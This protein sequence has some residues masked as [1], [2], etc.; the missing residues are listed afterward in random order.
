MTVSAS[1]S[2][3][4]GAAPSPCAGAAAR[5]SADRED[6]MT[7][8]AG[9]R[10]VSKNYGAT[11]RCHPTDLDLHTGVTGLLG[12]NGAGKSTLLRLLA[13]A[14]PPSAGTIAVAG[15]EVTGSLAERTE[16][17]RLVGY[18]PQEL[19]L[20]P[21]SRPSIPRLHRRPQGMDRHQLPAPGGTPGARPGRPRRPRH[22]AHQRP[23]RRATPPPRA[24]P[25]P[26]RRSRS[27]S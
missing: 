15:H 20:P 23:L 19:G 11:T 4:S 22:Q 21:V 5:R 17:R 18:L 7:V 16:A 8:V 3:C 24:R 12:P 14:Q 1:P 2:L 6:G 13:T 26:D 27:W 10:G 25:V 9:L